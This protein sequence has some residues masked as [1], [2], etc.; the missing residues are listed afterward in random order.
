MHV[1]GLERR[2]IAANDRLKTLGDENHNLSL[3][4]DRLEKVGDGL[5]P[6]NC[7]CALALTFVHFLTTKLMF[8]LL[9]AGIGN[10]DRRTLKSKD[11]KPG[12]G[13][14][15]SAEGKGGLSRTC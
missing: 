2:L 13:H 12:E 3:A 14:H 5:N 6:L 7:I 8:L 11:F 9:H 4:K 15:S 10:R 1:Q